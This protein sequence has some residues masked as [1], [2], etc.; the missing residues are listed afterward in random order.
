[1]CT[2]T[3]ALNNVVGFG[4]WTLYTPVISNLTF[5]NSIAGKCMFL[6]VWV[7][8]TSSVFEHEL[9]LTWRIHW[10][11]KLL[12][13]YQRANSCSVN[14]EKSPNSHS[15]FFFLARHSASKFS[16]LA[17]LPGQAW[18]EQPR[19]VLTPQPKRILMPG[20]ESPPWQGSE[21]TYRPSCKK[22]LSLLYSNSHSLMNLNREWFNFFLWLRILQSWR[23]L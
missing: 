4:L 14:S 5:S 18:V 19:V 2:V 16:I 13:L 1:M 17:E 11:V 6:M 20:R 10:R 23:M 12:I 9:Q 15:A 21:N 8:S 22:H 7:E 3:A